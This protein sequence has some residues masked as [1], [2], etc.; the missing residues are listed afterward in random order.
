[1]QA[2]EPTYVKLML[3]IYDPRLYWPLSRMLNRVY[4]QMSV[5][6]MPAMREFI[7]EPL[8]I[9][10]RY[11]GSYV[12]ISEDG[13]FFLQISST[14]FTKINLLEKIMMCSEDVYAMQ[15]YGYTEKDI[16]DIEDALLH[17]AGH[18]LCPF[19]SE[20]MSNLLSQFLVMAIMWHKTCRKVQWWRIKENKIDVEELKQ[21]RA[22]E[23]DIKNVLDKMC[24]IEKICIN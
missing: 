4:T 1:M 13:E 9:P 3:G 24:E 14:T 16:S 15:S 11:E 23:V 19:D 17:G 8:T 2:A 21:I 22:R 20:I 5:T 18:P 12:H 7:D 10:K 6:Q